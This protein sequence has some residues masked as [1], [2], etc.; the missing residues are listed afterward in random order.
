MQTTK[1]QGNF[2]KVLEKIVSQMIVQNF[3]KTG[4]NPKELELLE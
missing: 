4:L 2:T 3:C 1:N